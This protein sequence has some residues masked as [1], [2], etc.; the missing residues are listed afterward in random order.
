MSFFTDKARE[1]KIG[2]F[3]A[4]FAG[5]LSLLIGLF[6]GNSFGKIIFNLILFGVIF[7]AIGFFVVIILNQFMPEL[8]E[9]EIIVVVEPPY[10]MVFFKYKS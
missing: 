8:F 6:A 7:Y 9:E 3:F 5:A 10:N 2:I 4:A 1:N